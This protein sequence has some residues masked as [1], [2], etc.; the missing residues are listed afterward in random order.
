MIINT[1]KQTSPLRKVDFLPHSKLAE[2]I[3]LSRYNF[4]L[5]HIYKISAKLSQIQDGNSRFL[6]IDSS[7]LLQSPIFLCSRKSNPFL[8]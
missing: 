4:S 7:M 6:F 3:K 2:V 8:F 5:L 1:R